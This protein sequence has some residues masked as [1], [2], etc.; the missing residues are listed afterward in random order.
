MNPTD[1]ISQSEKRRIIKDNAKA[2]GGTYFSHGQ[3][4]ADTELGGRYGVINKPIVSGNEAATK[5]PR[6]P[7]GNPWSG[8]ADMGTEPFTG[9]AIDEQEPVGEA[10]EVQKSMQ[11]QASS[12]AASDEDVAPPAVHPP[13]CAGGAS[14]KRRRL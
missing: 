5:Y 3:A 12:S 6:L 14:K 4:A 2:R 13:I 10:F 7:E 9:Y 8:T 1:E 11:G